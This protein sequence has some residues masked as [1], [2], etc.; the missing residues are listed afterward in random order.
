MR[1]LIV[2]LLLSGCGAV[3][4][5]GGRSIDYAGTAQFEETSTETSEEAV[6]TRKGWILGGWLDRGGLGQV[7]RVGF[8]Y[9][10]VDLTEAPL[11]CG[12]V[13]FVETEE[14][15]LQAMELSESLFKGGTEPCVA[16]R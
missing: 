4:T 2:L 14:Q 3:V 15:L 7:A 10:S 9:R 6:V 1:I 11:S 12:V 8:G 5:D 16:Q 13:I